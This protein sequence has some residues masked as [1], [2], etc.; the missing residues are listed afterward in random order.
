MFWRLVWGVGDYGKR[1]SVTV[2]LYWHNT[3]IL[4]NSHVINLVL[5]LI[6]ICLFWT[7]LLVQIPILM[8]AAGFFVISVYIYK[9][10]WQIILLCPYVLHVFEY[11]GWIN[12]VKPCP[13]TNLGGQTGDSSVFLIFNSL[14]YPYFHMRTLLNL[15]VGLKYFHGRSKSVE[16]CHLH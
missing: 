12:N 16:I 7:R 5:K 2:S 1:V 3:I 8:T 15:S 4:I 14:L 6:N 13:F 9:C 10:T 11:S